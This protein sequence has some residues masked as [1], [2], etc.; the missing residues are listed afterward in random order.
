MSTLLLSDRL[1]DYDNGAKPSCHSKCS[2]GCQ[3]H[4]LNMEGGPKFLREQLE[5]WWGANATKEWRDSEL[6]HEI[7]LHAQKI[8]GQKTKA[9]WFI[10]DKQVCRNFYLRVRGIHHE[11]VRKMEKQ[12]LEHSNSIRSVVKD[13]TVKKEKENVRKMVVK[14][15]L[16]NYSRK[17]CEQSSTEKNV[18]VLPFRNVRP[19]YTVYKLDFES[20]VSLQ[21]QK[22]PLSS[23]QFYNCKLFNIYSNELKIRLKRNTGKFLSCTVCDAYDAR[24]REAK[25]DAQR[26]IL[27]EFKRRHHTKQESQRQK[28]Y[29][30]R[31]KAMENPKRYLSIII[32]GM[33]QKKTNCPV[34][35][36]TVKDESPLTQRV[37]GVKVHGIGNFVYV[38]D[39]TVRGGGNLII[40]VLRQTLLHVEKIGKLPY[41]NPVLY[42][43]IDNC[44]ENKNK[45][46]F[47][48]LTDLVRKQV[49]CKV[50]ACFLMVGHTHNDIDQ[51]FATIAGHL[52]QIHVICP[53]RESLFQAIKD[54]FLK[55]EDKPLIIPLAAT[56]VYD[57]TAFYKKVIDKHISYHQM[58]HQ[59]R[60]KTFKTSNAECREVVLV[61]YKNWAES[62][63]WLPR[64]GELGEMKLKGSKGQLTRGQRAEKIRA[65]AS[66]QAISNQVVSLPPTDIPE[67]HGYH[68]DDESSDLLEAEA[69]FPTDSFQ[70][71]GITWLTTPTS[72]DSFPLV[73][74]T[75]QQIAAN[76]AKVQKIYDDILLKFTPKYREIFSET[77]LDNWASWLEVET[78]RWSLGSKRNMHAQLL[79]PA[80]Y[81]VRCVAVDD[82]AETLVVDSAKP[83]VDERTEY[84]SHDSGVFGSLTKDQQHA[85]LAAHDG[86]FIDEEASSPEID[87]ILENMACIYKFSYPHLQS[88]RIIEQIAVGIVVKVV[89]AASQDAVIDIRFCPPKGAKPQTHSREDT[90]YQDISAD[91]TFN[92]KYLTTKKSGGHKLKVP[93]IETQQQRDV[94]L[95]YNLDITR[96]GRFGKQPRVGGIGETYTSLQFAKGVIDRFYQQRKEGESVL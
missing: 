42:L 63:Y 33:D 14:D 36:R 86:V 82:L 56:D 83:D 55:V 27:L 26:A 21:T 38:C 19:I 71:R 34:M 7:L 16:Y 39:E 91:M 3:Q 32:D 78:H 22:Q 84:V 65:A 37:I 17:F 68:T 31:R 52:A 25:T 51:V 10:G 81:S 93:D 70:L 11:F 12:L 59:F 94:L 29:R 75:D 44:G 6:A 85:A 67:N 43:Q 92:L 4:F 40:E 54:A 87:T 15:W 24:I 64:Y 73:A 60:I 2:C 41:I 48:F 62:K 76:A 47:A 45:T 28:Y 58:P 18:T 50:K 8:E 13:K 80:P 96:D 1:K 20:D 46:L 66:K 74:F 77:V 95:A 5:K 30:H 9:R 53:D 90:L 79:I 57:Y 89:D 49:F 23:S 69:Q 35:G 61:H 72:F 88:G